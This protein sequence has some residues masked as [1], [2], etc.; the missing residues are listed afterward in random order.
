ME[1]VE[2]GTHAVGIGIVGV[3]E[4]GC[5]VAFR[6]F[7]AHSGQ[8]TGGKPFRDDVHRNA[9]DGCDCRRSG[10]I[11]RLMFTGKTPVHS[12]PFSG[13]VVQQFKRASGDGAAAVECFHCG[14]VA[15]AVAEYRM[16]PR[17]ACH[18]FSSC[19]VQRKNGGA[20]RCKMTEQLG[21]L[22]RNAFQRAEIFQMTASDGNDQRRIG[23]DSP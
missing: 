3:V 5:T 16:V 19:G 9:E 21:F 13:P 18:D 7:H 10:C 20:V 6:D 8:D 4:P 11:A 23:A 22:R 12:D 1:P 15:A 2:R 14:A 17:C